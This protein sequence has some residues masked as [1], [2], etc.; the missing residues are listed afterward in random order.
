MGLVSDPTR[1]ME[2]LFDYGNITDE[3]KAA[4]L[5]IANYL[6]SKGLG[7][8][9]SAIKVKFKIVEIPKYNVEASPIVA[10]FKKAGVYCSV[11]GYVQ[12]G[13]EPDIMQYPLLSISADIRQLEELIPIVKSMEIVDENN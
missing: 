7:E 5:E 12:E 8:I 10:A 13:V 6:E 2:Y 11:Q 3:N 4:A 9:A 1:N